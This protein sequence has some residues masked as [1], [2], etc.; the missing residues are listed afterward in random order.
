M[1][2]RELHATLSTNLASVPFASGVNSHMGSLFSE[3]LEPMTWMM[4]ALV[5]RPHP[6]LFFVDSRTTP[7]SV[8]AA[9]AAVA[10]IAHA[11]R[12]V[13]LDNVLDPRAIRLQLGILTER[14]AEHGQAIGIGHPHQVTLD[15]LEAELGRLPAELVPVS[16]L[17]E[18]PA[19][20]LAG[21]SLD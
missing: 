3:H 18:G 13:F 6:R 12:D 14:A 10:G 7:R 11:T 4:E 8:S 19:T 15:V 17:L 20:S 2:R 9:A 21:R 16:E 1:T 5:A